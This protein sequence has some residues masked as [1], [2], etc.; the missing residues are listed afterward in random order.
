MIEF[1]LS[2]KVKYLIGLPETGHTI[3]DV[4]FQK[5]YT[6]ETF[7]VDTMDEAVKIA[8]EKTEKGKSCL[9]SPAASSYNRYK[10]F[11]EKGNHFKTLC[12]QYGE[13]TNR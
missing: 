5:G 6:G 2:G 7:K 1:L 13:K 12:K 8:Y 11:E 10:N 3:I 9:F 4:L